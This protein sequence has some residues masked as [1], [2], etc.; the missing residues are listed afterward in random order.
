MFPE[1]PLTD[2]RNYPPR[3]NLP[4]GNAKLP[5]SSL[6]GVRFVEPLFFSCRRYVPSFPLR[7]R[8]LSTR[9]CHSAEKIK[10]K[11][12]LKEQCCIP[13]KQNALFVCQ[14]EDVL[15]VYTR[16]YDPRFPRLC[17]DERSLAVARGQISF[18]EAFAPEEAV[19]V[20][21]RFTTADAL[22][23]LKHL[24]EE[25]AYKRLQQQSMK[26]RRSMR[27][28]AEAVILSSELS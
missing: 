9:V 2:Q 23:K 14:M 4:C 11:P 21:W 25:E 27:E 3:P 17:M 8:L 15:R 19:P 5:S 20:D 7:L 26:T 24:S 13:A 18:Y 1:A 12:W 6:R 22:M 16:P 28:I 10:L